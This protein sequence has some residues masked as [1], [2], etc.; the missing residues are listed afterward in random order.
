MAERKIR[1]GNICIGAKKPILVAG[2][3]AIEDRGMAMKTAQVLAEICDKLNMPF[4]F[5]ASYD[6]ANRLS[7][8]SG[9]GIGFPKGLL[10]LREIRE[11]IEVPV[12]TDVH[13]TY[14]VEAVASVVDII[15]IPAFLCRQ[16]DLVLASAKTKKTI[17]IK[18]GQFM[19]PS[20]MKFI[21]EKAE[22]AGNRKI[23][24]IERG[25]CFGYRD[26]V[27][28]PR[29]IVWLREIGYPV[30]LDIT[31][32]AQSPGGTG[33]ASSGDRKWATHYAKVGLALDIEGIYMEVHPDPEKA[34]SDS[35]VQ[36]PLNEVELLLKKI[37]K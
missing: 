11:K 34:I 30:L 17:S 8:R 31:H 29:S 37:F 19:A 20:D 33:G 13:E 32:S 14:Q 22:S 4:I 24:L 21:V 6:K 35:A 23:I 26:L 10:I 27:L 25:T 2:P 15:Q 5:K 16:T 9:R 1:V 28:D 7:I 18:K 36:I 3:C 12:L